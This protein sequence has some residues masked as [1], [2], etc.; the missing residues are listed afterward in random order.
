MWKKIIDYFVT[1]PI[2]VCVGFPYHV[3]YL[4]IGQSTD[5]LHDSAEFSLGDFS[6][7]VLVVALNTYIDAY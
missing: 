1:L 4:R 2:T 3:R 6:I 7:T 5:L